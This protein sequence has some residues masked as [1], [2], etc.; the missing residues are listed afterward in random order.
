MGRRLFS[1][2]PGDLTAVI[3]CGKM[4]GGRRLFSSSGGGAP[5]GLGAAVVGCGKMGEAMVRG[6]L[7]R[8]PPGVR[9]VAAS[10]LNAD[11][12]DLF[13]E[14][15]VPA[16]TPSNAEAVA[17]ADIVILAVK[18]QHVRAVCDEVAPAVRPGALVLSICAGTTVGFL[19]A[20]LGTPNVIRAMPN[21]PATIGAGITCWTAT[22]AMPAAQLGAAR[23]ILGS[24]GEEVFVE[25]EE[26]IDMATA[27]S[28]SGPA[29]VFLFM[30]CLID[31]GVHIGFPRHVAT[32]LVQQT[33]LGSAQYAVES[34][35]VHPAQLKNDITSPAGTSA[36]AL[37]AAERGNFKTVI[38]DSVW[39]AYRRSLELGG[40]ASDVGP[41]RSQVTSASTDMRR[42]IRTV[43]DMDRRD[44][45]VAGQRHDGGPHGAE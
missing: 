18:P 25:E 15:G 32:K 33:M 30:E 45:V 2:A 19:S 26:M 21:T 42:L 6:V 16:V 28:G 38:S 12:R 40:I 22:P 13:A 39:A 36:A 27:I 10:D 41:G 44:G 29:Y 7:A 37:Y 35:G 5:G 43:S 9:L 11:R 8:R 1:S 31:A 14:L 34:P 23:A 3:G 20:A 24:L 4:G 17:G